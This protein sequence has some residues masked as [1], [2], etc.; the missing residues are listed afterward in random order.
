LA[1]TARLPRARIAVTYNP[2]VTD[3]LAVAARAPVAHP[4]LQPGEPP[5]VLGVGKLK[6]QKG[7]DVLLRAFAHLRRERSARLVILGEGPQRRAPE[8]LARALGSAPD[9]AL[10]GFV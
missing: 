9:A 10:R 1:R 6:S 7:F 8:R 4:W 2:V 3:A 5:V